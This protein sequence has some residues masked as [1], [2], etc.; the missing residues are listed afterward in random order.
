MTEGVLLVDKPA[1][2]TSHDVVTAVRRGLGASKAGHAGTLDPFAT[3]LLVLGLG[4]WTRVLE[5]LSGLD[6]TYEATARLG[7][8]TDTLDPEGRV[9]SEDERWRSLGRA[10]VEAAARG[11]VGALRLSPPVYSAVKVGG[12]AAHRLARRGQDVRLPPRPCTVRAFDVL[13]APLPEVRF[14]V[15]C[16]SGTYVRALAAE[17]GGRLGTACHL[18]AL[19]RTR[20]GSFHVD[21]A[22][23]LDAL[24][25]APP[26][27]RARVS[28]ADALAHLPR[29]ELTPEEAA[30]VAQG[31]RVPVASAS[32]SVNGDAGQ[33]AAFAGDGCL[34]AVGALRD[35]VLRPRKVFARG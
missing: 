24:R 25:D 16:S 14:R 7:R 3:G 12:T 28:L 9:V 20:T 29:I 2:P 13:D 35:G 32:A 34:V 1:G 17:L 33:T 8:A 23:S 19:R 5:Y 6:K 22:V 18:T 26:P 11:L 27:A 10:G 21:A 15:S 30:A 31:R 4:R